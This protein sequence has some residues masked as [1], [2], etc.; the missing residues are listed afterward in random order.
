MERRD[1]SGNAECFRGVVATRPIVGCR[2]EAVQVTAHR[3]VEGGDCS[4]PGLEI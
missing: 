4:D 3:L 1:R 2:E